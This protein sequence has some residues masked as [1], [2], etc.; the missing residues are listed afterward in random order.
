MFSTLLSGTSPNTSPDALPDTSPDALPDTSPNTTPDAL[1]DTSPNTTPDALPDT[2]PDLKKH[3]MDIYNASTILRNCS[4]R[5]EIKKAFEALNAQIASPTTNTTTDEEIKEAFEAFEALKKLVDLTSD[6][7]SELIDLCDEVRNPIVSIK[8][9]SSTQSCTYSYT[10]GMYSLISRIHS[11]LWK[12]AIPLNKIPKQITTDK[13]MTVAIT[14]A[15]AY[16]DMTSEALYVLDVNIKEI[17]KI[18]DELKK[19]HSVSCSRFT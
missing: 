17:F 4:T 16:Y 19:E 2:S 9:S 3:V 10:K 6:Y 5:N 12:T 18:L 15:K 11:S 13:E 8:D 1:P 7:I 14:E